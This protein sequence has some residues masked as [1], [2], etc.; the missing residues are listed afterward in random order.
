MKGSESSAAATPTAVLMASSKSRWRTGR[1][2][3]APV[4]RGTWGTGGCGLQRLRSS[5][6]SAMFGH[7][8]REYICGY[9]GIDLA[10]QR[11]G[12][13]L[14]VSGRGVRGNA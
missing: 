9:Y 14:V 10:L 7:G 12:G 6:I 3:P 2:I 1:V 13:A 4:S 11:V 8:L 5:S